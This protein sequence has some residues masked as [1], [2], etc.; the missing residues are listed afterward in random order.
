LTFLRYVAPQQKGGHRKM[1][2]GLTIWTASLRGR[3]ENSQNNM[4]TKLKVPAV[5]LMVGV[6]LECVTG[7]LLSCTRA[8][9]SAL[10]PID[11]AA[12]K[13]MM[14]TVRSNFN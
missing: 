11:Q 1:R 12:L 9:L 8:R 6:A 13:T 7:L 14:D 5:V 3:N 2:S 4:K 10:K